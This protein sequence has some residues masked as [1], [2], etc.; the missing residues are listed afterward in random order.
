MQDD[1]IEIHVRAA[2]RPGIETER[3]LADLVGYSWPGGTQDRTDPA[4]RGWL[5]HFQAIRPIVAAAECTCQAGRCSS[6]N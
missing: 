3:L 2:C 4:A 6:C 1:T 5:R